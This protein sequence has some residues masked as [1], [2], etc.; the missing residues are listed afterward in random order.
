MNGEAGPFVI[1]VFKR[2]SGVLQIA[3]SLS[4]P[5]EIPAGHTASEA[6]SN[7]VVLTSDGLGPVRA[8]PRERGPAHPIFTIQKNRSV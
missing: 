6:T 3:F 7:A 1:L 2:V 5:I 8:E 4:P